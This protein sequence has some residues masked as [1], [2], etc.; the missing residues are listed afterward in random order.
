M[1]VFTGPIAQGAEILAARE[2]RGRYLKKELRRGAPLLCL[3]L[4][5]PGPQKRGPDVLRVHDV[6][7]RRVQAAFPQA[8]PCAVFVDAAGP[9]ALWRLLMDG[10]EAKRRAISLE[11]ADALGRLMDLDVLE[12]EGPLSRSAV[13]APPRP[14]FLCAKDARICRRLGTHSPE[15]IQ[16]HLEAIVRSVLQR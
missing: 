15:A 13:G 6:A 16:A 2:R 9:F 11:Q 8:I 7:R 5:I 12:G 4:N 10:T 14:C 1:E 3:T